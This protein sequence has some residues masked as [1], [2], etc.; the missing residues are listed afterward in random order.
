MACPANCIYI[1]AA[2][3]TEVRPG[4][5]GTGVVPADDGKQKEAEERADGED[6]TEWNWAALAAFVNTRWKLGVND[7]ELRRISSF[8]VPEAAAAWR[9]RTRISS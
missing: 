3:N 7:R 2:E 4:G 5:V 8:S 1:E 9:R 6:E